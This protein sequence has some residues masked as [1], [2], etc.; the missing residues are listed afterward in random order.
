MLD[1]SRKNA[2]LHLIHKNK[3]DN[4]W[5]LK[6]NNYT[7]FD[8]L[9]EIIVDGKTYVIEYEPERDICTVV[10]NYK[11]HNPMHSYCNQL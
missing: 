1:F 11:E 8:N 2:F 4:K 10:Q 7:K 6:D 9:Y 3:W 5:Y